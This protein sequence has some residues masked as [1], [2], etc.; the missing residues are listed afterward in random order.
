LL[1]AVVH[2]LLAQAPRR[3]RRVQRP[4]RQASNGLP[5]HLTGGMS[6][7]DALHSAQLLIGRSCL[8]GGGAGHLLIAPG[9]CRWC[10]VFPV[11]GAASSQPFTRLRESNARLCL[12]DAGE[13]HDDYRVSLDGGAGARLR[14]GRYPRL[15]RQALSL[16]NGADAGLRPRRCP[17]L[18]RQAVLAQRLRD[19]SRELPRPGVDE[20]V[21]FDC[22]RHVGDC[23]TTLIVGRNDCSSTR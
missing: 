22:I 9:P 7:P 6:R 21:G 14:L 13:K 15:L 2:A 5:P 17:R 16:D 23:T 4:A 19:E 12:A 20:R 1:A 11:D 3:R 18:R 8:S 10:R